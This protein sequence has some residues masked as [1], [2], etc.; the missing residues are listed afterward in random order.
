MMKV[1]GRVHPL[2]YLVLAMVAFCACLAPVMGGLNDSNFVVLLVAW[3]VFIGAFCL[4]TFIVER[5][6]IKEIRKLYLRDR[7][8][9]SFGAGMARSE[10]LADMLEKCILQFAN[11]D[12]N[13]RLRKM[14]P[15]FNPKYVIETNEFNFTCEHG[16]QTQ[17]QTATDRA[18]RALG[19]GGSMQALASREVVVTNWRGGVRNL[20]TGAFRRFNS[21]DE[22]ELILSRIESGR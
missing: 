12:R 13:P 11:M 14:P 7:D 17:L 5:R 15:S 21:I 19:S 4:V 10:D 16:F 8:F 18:L 22:L 3:F 6:K 1:L 20:E 2:T 9:F